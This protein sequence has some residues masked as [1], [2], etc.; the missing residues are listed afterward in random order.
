MRYCLRL[1]AALLC[2]SGCATRPAPPA[3]APS[4]PP[5]TI[6]PPPPTLHFVIYGDTRSRPD[7]H[8]Q[9]VAQIAAVKPQFVIQTGD[10]VGRGTA[11]DEWTAFLEITAPLRE[12]GDYYPVM[13]NH[14]RG[15]PDLRTMFTAMPAEPAGKTYY[16]FVRGNCRF[17]VLDT[18]TLRL[19]GK[20]EDQITWLTGVL[21]QARETHLL[22]IGHH[23]LY[24]IGEYAPGD[25]TVRRRLEPLFAR[26][27]VAAYFCGHDHGYYR[28]RRGRLM[29]VITAG[30]GAP[31]Y[32]QKP[33]LAQAGDVF[34]KTLNFTDLRVEGD[35]IAIRAIDGD[36]QVFDTFE[37]VA[38]PAAATP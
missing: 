4:A 17:V 28:T 33:E 7:K 1:T 15:G 10:M 2:L 30:G 23:P 8:R 24:A 12:L 37:L 29:H 31:L 11:Q 27:Q 25:L 35:R 9:V 16:T 14:D 18:N 36:G 21:D 34:K 22:V 26:H 19:E 5:P 6:A 38:T 13:G 20:D 3:P 32:E